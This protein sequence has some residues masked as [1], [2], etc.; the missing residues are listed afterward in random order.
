[1]LRYS[2]FCR[3]CKEFPSCWLEFGMLNLGVWPKKIHSTAE[4]HNDYEAQGQSDQTGAQEL[5]KS[6]DRDSEAMTE[7]HIPVMVDE[8]VRC[9]APQKGQ[10]SVR[11]HGC[12]PMCPSFC[13]CCQNFFPQQHC[14]FCHLKSV[15][16]FF[17]NSLQMLLLCYVIFYRSF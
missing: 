14:F 6:Q 16:I 15:L 11:L 12:L 13:T 8:V 4:V 9:L 17:H 1:M 5:H 2:Y 3:I 10:N 7:L